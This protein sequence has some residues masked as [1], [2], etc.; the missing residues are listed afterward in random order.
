MFA[1]YAF[2]VLSAILIFFALMI[3]KSKRLLHAVL[4]LTGVFFMSSVVLLLLGQ[5]LAA[6]LQLVIL[7]GGM[8][9]YL[10]VAVA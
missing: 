5:P 1:A 2:V 10:I 4:A 6:L 9:T 7:V 3:F 8:S